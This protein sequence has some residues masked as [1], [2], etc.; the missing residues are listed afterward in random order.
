MGA[1]NGKGGR[2][3]F[4]S[5]EILTKI[6]IHLGAHCISVGEVAV[7]LVGS[8][9]GLIFSELSCVLAVVGADEGLEHSQVA[10]LASFA[11]EELVRLACP[12][13]IGALEF[14]TVPL[15]GPS[16]GHGTFEL[17]VLLG[18]ADELRLCDHG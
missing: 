3:G 5:K 11:F 18:P 12:L 8:R 17:A 6:I 4:W 2:E 15:D 7:H 10:E 9:L 14:L 1:R 16:L 13:R